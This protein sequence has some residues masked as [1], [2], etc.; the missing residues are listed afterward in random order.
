MLQEVH[1]FVECGLQLPDPLPEPA[2]FQEH[3]PKHIGHL[4]A[5]VILPQTIRGVIPVLRPAFIVVEHEVQDGDDHHRLEVEVPSEPLSVI[6]AL[7]LPDILLLGQAALLVDRVAGVEHRTLTK[8]LLISLLYLNDQGPP[9]RTLAGDV[10]Y[11]LAVLF[12]KT[13]MLR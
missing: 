13:E 9:V 3:V 4:F 6:L 2:E 5:G 8:V 12:R 1:P 11:G 10:E 7:V